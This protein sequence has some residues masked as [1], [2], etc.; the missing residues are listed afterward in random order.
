MATGETL[1]IMAARYGEGFAAST[2]AAPLGNRQRIGDVTVR[3]TPAGH[4]L[5]SA[6]IVI[7]A[8]GTRIVVSGDYKR[9]EDRPACPMS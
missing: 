2:Q 7:E 6:Q 8:G 5:G 1:R 9:S 3:F 4:V